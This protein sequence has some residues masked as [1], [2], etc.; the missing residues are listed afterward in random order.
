M[1]GGIGVLSSYRL[2]SGLRGRCLGTLLC[3]RLSQTRRHYYNV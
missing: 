3:G 1:G 2:P